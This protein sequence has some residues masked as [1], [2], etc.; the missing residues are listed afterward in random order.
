M[1]RLTREGYD[2][3]EEWSINYHVLLPTVTL[4]LK[5]LTIREPICLIGS[6]G[7]D[8]EPLEYLRRRAEEAATSVGGTS[9]LASLLDIN[10]ISLENFINQRPN[11]SGN[12]RSLSIDHLNKLMKSLGVTRHK[13]HLP[14]GFVSADTPELMREMIDLHY[15]L[16]R[17]SNITRFQRG[18]WHTNRSPSPGV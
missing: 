18:T 2:L 10:R 4:H 6:G 11:N 14:G 1:I 5:G 8:M 12:P 7:H 16:L 17:A 3:S 9:K 15:E 13:A